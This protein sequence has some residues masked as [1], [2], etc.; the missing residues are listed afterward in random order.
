LVQDGRQ[1]SQAAINL[2]HAMIA[3][4]AKKQAAPRTP[5]LALAAVSQKI[6]IREQ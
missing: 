3:L 1:G 2:A 5:H 4:F 6:M